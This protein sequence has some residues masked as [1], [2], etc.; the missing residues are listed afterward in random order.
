MALRLFK[1]FKDLLD[2]PAPSTGKFLSWD[3]NGN[4]VNADGA[5]LPTDPSFNSVTAAAVSTFNLGVKLGPN[6][7]KVYSDATYAF[8]TTSAR[9]DTSLMVAGNVSAL[10]ITTT[11]A[12]GSG[13]TFMGGAVSS[14]TAVSHKFFNFGSLTT[15]GDKLIS[16]YSDNNA[17]ERA[18]IDRLGGYTAKGTFASIATGSGGAFT[19]AASNT[20]NLTANA[21]STGSATGTILNN[22]QT[23]VNGDKLLSVRNNGTEKFAVDYN[24]AIYTNGMSNS[25]GYVGSNAGFIGNFSYP[26]TLQG[27]VADGASAVNAIIDTFGNSYATVGAK[28]LSIR[29]NTVE[30]VQVTYDGTVYAVGSLNCAGS[31][32]SAN[33]SGAFFGRSIQNNTGTVGFYGNSGTKIAS[34]FAFPGSVWTEQAYI[35][36]Q[37]KASFSGLIGTPVAVS[38]ISATGTPDG[39][40][41]L[42][43]DGTWA[44]PTASIPDATAA[45][46]G[47]IKLTGDLGGTAA[48]PT[49]PGLAGKANSSHTHGLADFTATGTPSATTYLRGDN[50]WSELTGVISK[51]SASNITNSTTT[52][53]NITGLSFSIAAGEVK[54]F[55]AV[56]IHQG[57]ATSGPRFNVTGPASPT[58]VAIHYHRGTSATADTI[59]TDTAFSTS[60]QTA[61]IT[62]GGNTG[63]LVTEVYGTVINGSNAGTV[64]FQLTSS[65][66]GQT[67]T[68][69]RG[70][71]IELT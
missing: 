39:T 68:V 4:L 57:T 3:A 32:F 45:V 33:G 2:A 19:A 59:S 50:T 10:G 22:T 47:G 35:D 41:Y 56:I 42:R 55:H 29:N 14:G 7:N 61:A 1:T 70:S 38:N 36:Y 25:A 27:R 48:S 6:T 24:G 16:V 71:H 20:L 49:V 66:S 18:F 37:G 12:G 64:K 62:S 54:G 28:L 11:N 63:I 65:T 40:T 15:S 13:L 51:V 58:T 44:A 46:T 26:I 9:F 34:F 21:P 52:P 67:V 69:Y 53:T 30:K 43:G 5:A 31:V 8:R 17:T 60:A 23:M